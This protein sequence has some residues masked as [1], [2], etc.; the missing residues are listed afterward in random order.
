VGKNPTLLRDIRVVPMKVFSFLLFFFV[1]EMELLFIKFHRPTVR[2]NFGERGGQCD[3]PNM[4]LPKN[5]RF[6]VSMICP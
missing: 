5:R 4:T 6:G 1:H 2:G 3:M